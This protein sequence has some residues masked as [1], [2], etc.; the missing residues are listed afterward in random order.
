MKRRFWIDKMKSC[1]ERNYLLHMLRRFE[2]TIICL[3]AAK[4]S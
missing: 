3:F 4:P 2:I 1:G